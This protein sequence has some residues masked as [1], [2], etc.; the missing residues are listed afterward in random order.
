MLCAISNDAVTTNQQR[1]TTMKHPLI[2]FLLLLC[3]T[4]TAFAQTSKIETGEING[5]PFR[6]E[7]PANWNKGLVMYCHGYE[8]VGAKTNVADPK[9]NPIRDEFINRE[10]GR[11]SRFIRRQICCSKRTLYVRSHANRNGV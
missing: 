9:P 10:A 5:A 6:I 1:I 4:F 2:I 7:V 3:C 8:T 11:D